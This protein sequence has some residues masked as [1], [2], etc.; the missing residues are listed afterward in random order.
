MGD[1]EVL[2]AANIY[3]YFKKK[4]TPF[5]VVLLPRTVCKLRRTKTDCMFVLLP[6]PTVSH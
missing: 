4:K 1:P 6:N 3:M 5:E 2:M